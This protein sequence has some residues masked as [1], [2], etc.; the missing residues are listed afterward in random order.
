MKAIVVNGSHIIVPDYNLGDCYKLESLLVKYDKLY[1]RY[2]PMAME[3][4]EEK[5]ELIIPSGMNLKYICKLLGR[6][7]LLSD[8]YDEFKSISLRLV[9]YPRS[10]IQNDLIRFLIGKN[11]YAGN[12]TEPQLIG[13]AET[14]EGKTFCAIAAMVF[15]R[16]KTIIIVNRKNIVKNW[17]D[18][19]VDYTD[20]D[21]KRILVLTTPTIN[22]ILKNP[23]LI[24]KYYIFITTHRTLQVNGNSQGWDFITNLFKT[25]GIGLKI[26]DEAHMEFSS[27]MKIDFHTNTRKTFYL[28]ANM[29][30]SAFDENTVF[31]RCFNRVPRF[32]QI[33]LGYTDS[34][35]HITMI[36]DKY[37]SHPSVKDSASCKNVQG[38]SKHAYS[39]YQVTGDREFFDR[40]NKFIKLFTVEKEYRTIVF[41][42][43]IDSC[44]TVAEYFRGIYPELSIGVYNSAIDKSEKQRVLDEDRLIISTSSSLGFSETISNLR[45]VINCEAFRSKITGNQASGRLRRLGEDI[46]CY[47][48]ELVDIGFSSIRA[49]FKERENRYKSQF[50]EIIYLE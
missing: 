9:K 43:K 30:R 47:Y 37:N 32:D 4:D 17:E 2:V 28:T 46:Q 15:L 42:S 40:L 36:V 49:Q 50:K 12:T 5:Q 23:K 25:L 45:C 19:I 11:E 22:R 10:E 26:Y 31:Q 18:C 24:D 3:Y 13:N 6:N 7:F 20:I 29:E 14:G 44:E 1:H 33:K 35:K 48:I 16:M 34:K 41:V 27:M 8:N 38:F 39:E 21:R